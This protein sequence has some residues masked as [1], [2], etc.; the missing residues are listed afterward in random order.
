MENKEIFN[1]VEKILR[2]ADV[3]LQEYDVPELEI[4]VTT[5]LG[6]LHAGKIHHLASLCLVFS[7]MQLDTIREIKE[8]K[9][10]YGEE[11]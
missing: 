3:Q 9:E 1:Q 8:L 5:M 10:K 7:Q 4:I 6:A 11:L 2:S